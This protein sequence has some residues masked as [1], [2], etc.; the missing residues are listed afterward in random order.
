LSIQGL[1]DRGLGA[2]LGLAVGDA[3]GTTL[4]FTRR[5]AQPHHTEMTGGG[6]FR[7]NPGEWTDDTAM[8][9]ALGE[10][11]LACNGL[12]PSDL[13]DRFVAWWNRGEYSCTGRCFDIG[14]TTSQALARYLRTKN[15][16][17][18]STSEEAAGNG[19]IMRLAPAVLRSVHDPETMGRIA[20]DQSRTT[21]AAPQ[22]LQGCERPSR[23][24]RPRSTSGPSSASSGD[25]GL[26]EP[27]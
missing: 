14:N 24:T 16:Y 18:G 21:H 4:E 26:S 7:L 8:A 17:S 27:T 13:M 3:L 19:S 10:S 15:P 5:D 22:A 1:E 23:R 25:V 11:L 9:L 20:R 12:H 2:M 6:P